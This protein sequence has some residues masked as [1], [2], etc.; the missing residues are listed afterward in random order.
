[1]KTKESSAKGLSRTL[2]VD[3]AAATVFEALT[4]R[5]GLRN[6][7]TAR[8]KGRGLAGGELR[9]EFD[10]LDEHI[11]MRVER[12]ARPTSV[13]WTCLE[14]TEL[15]EWAGTTITFDLTPSDTN[16]CQ[17]RFQHAGLT[18]KL[19]CFDDCKAGWNHF[20]ASLVGYVERGEGQ[21]FGAS[22]RPPAARS[23]KRAPSPARTLAAT[24]GAGPAGAA[25]FH[26]IVRSFA[27]DKTVEA[28]EAKRGA[29]G[30]NGLKVHGRIFAMLV[31]GELVVKLPRARVAELIAGGGGAPFDAGKGKAMKEWLTVRAPVADWLGLAREARAF[32][33]RGGA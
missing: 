25:A 12:A 15:D 23:K 13:M 9:F 33:T 8:V 18:P 5:V 4:T 2:L 28:P 29:F 16:R 31:R 10:G 7:W 20:L 17:L 6:W 1:M 19:A 32:V 14:H 11:T 22:P 30:S 21:P 3:A 26:E 24:P 27:R